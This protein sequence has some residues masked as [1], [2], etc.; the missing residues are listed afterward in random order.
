MAERRL[1]D[2]HAAGSTDAGGSGFAKYQVR[3]SSNGGLHLRRRLGRLRH[4]TVSNEG[5]NCGAVPLRRQRRQ[6]VGVG[7]RLRAHRP[8]RPDRPE[9]RGRRQQL[10]KSGTSVTVY[11]DRLERRRLAALATTSSR[12]RRTAR[13]G[14]PS[15]AGSK[16]TI[17][18]AGPLVRALP[19]GGQGRVTCPPGRRP[20]SG[21]TAAI[22]PCRPSPAARTRWTNA[23]SVTVTASGATDAVSGMFSYQYRKST[24]GGNTWSLAGQRLVREHHRGRRDAAAVPLDRQRRPPLGVRLRRR[25][26][27]AARCGSTASRRPTRP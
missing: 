1:G 9:R 16:A 4:G 23:S 20:T 3:W 21:S 7:D 17:T 5:N 15:T 22:R 6:R 13:P 18:H 27:R 8:H 10:W 11:G 19:R 26:R 14:R 2:A 25:R 12:P 24:D